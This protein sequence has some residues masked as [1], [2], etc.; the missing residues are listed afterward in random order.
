MAAVKWLCENWIYAPIMSLPNQ[1]G[2]RGGDAEAPAEAGEKRSFRKRL[3]AWWE[4]YEAPGSGNAAEA[5]SQAAA[6]PPAPSAPAMRA[7]AAAD[8]AK[9]D[10]DAGK[11]DRHGKPLWTATRIDVAEKLWGKGFVGPGG[12]DY[13]PDLV[14]PLGL[15]K[16][17][18]VLDLSAGLGGITRMIATHSGAWVTGLELSPML[19]ERGAEYTKKADLTKQAPISHY[20]PNHLSPGRKFDA[21]FAKEI[22]FCL[23]K[24]KILTQ[25]KQCLKPGGQLLFTD[26]LL[27]DSINLEGLGGWA[28]AERL[29]PHPWRPSETAACLKSLGFDLRIAQDMT[30]VQLRLIMTRLAEFHD[31]LQ[32][33]EL[34]AETRHAV[35]V[36]VALWARR[37][38]ALRHGLKLY[39]V[40]CLA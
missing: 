29:E 32:E 2:A 22:F 17:M 40:H 24:E 37:A 33:H 9:P 26:Y 5:H 3:H 16:T 6:S 15:D 23:D 21:I 1:T 35:T 8:P 7:Q 30:D 36:E 19:A 39:R 18:S 14:K 20:D 34:D 28:E 31:F 11:L 10:P 25:I 12:E 27:A 4:G 13:V 38:E